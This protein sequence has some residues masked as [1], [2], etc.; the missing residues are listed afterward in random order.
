MLT[1]M[2]LARLSFSRMVRDD[3]VRLVSAFAPSGARILDF[4]GRDGDLAEGLL[5][6][7]FQVGI[8]EPTEGRRD[9]GVF[10]NLTA[11]TNWLGFF[12]PSSREQFDIVCVFG[13]LEHFLE[14]TFREDMALLATYCTPGGKIIGTVPL[15]EAL[16]QGYCLCPGCASLFHRWQHQR[17]F[18][19]ESLT[20][21]LRN[22]GLVHCHTFVIDFSIC[23]GFAAGFKDFPLPEAHVAAPQTLH[24][25]L[26][27]ARHNETRLRAEHASLQQRVEV[28]QGAREQLQH[29]RDTVG[30]HNLETFKHH[31]FAAKVL[32]YAL[33]RV[34]GI[35][36]RIPGFSRFRRACTKFLHMASNARYNRSLYFY[37][38]KVAQ[39]MTEDW[40]TAA[41]FFP[42]RPLSPQALTGKPSLLFFCGTLGA[43][44]A[45]R[46]LANL[47]IRMHFAGH[48]VKVRLL[49]LD[50]PEAHYAP[51][52]RK[53]GIDCRALSCE[54]IEKNASYLA[55]AGV[56][57]AL[58]SALPLEVRQNTAA[59]AAEVLRE[60]VDLIHTFLD[61]S[62]IIAAWAG[63]L[64][65]TPAMR[66]SCRNLNPSRFFYYQPWM[67]A[68]YRWLARQPRI[69]LEANSRAAAR[70]YE[71]WLDLPEDSINVSPNGIDSAQ[72]VTLSDTERKQLRAELGVPHGAPLVISVGRIGPEKRP[73]DLMHVF[74]RTIE[75]MPKAHCVHV[76]H[77]LLARDIAL[78]REKLPD[79]QK[80]NIHLLGLRQDIFR[81]LAASDVFVL[82]SEHESMP[83]AVME[84]MLSGL[85][86]VATNAGGT[87]ELV[88]EGQTGFLRD[89][90]DIAGL[91]EKTVFL[92]CNPTLRE[93]MG[94]AGKKRMEEFSFD[95]LMEREQ[96]AYQKQ[97]AGYSIQEKTGKKSVA[98]YSLPSMGHFLRIQSRMLFTRHVQPDA[99]TP[100][101]PGLSRH[102]ELSP[103]AHEGKP[104]VTFFLGTLGSGGAER[105]VCL[106]ARE[107]KRKGCLVRVVVMNSIGLNGHRL[108]WLREEGIPCFALHTHLPS[109][110]L[111]AT[112]L[113]YLNKVLAMLPRQDRADCMALCAYLAQDPPDVLHCF[114]DHSNIIGAYAGLLTGIPALR[115]SVCAMNP[116]NFAFYQEWW[117][118]SYQ[119]LLKYPQIRLE[120]NSHFVA[121]DYQ[122]W[123]NLPAASEFIPTAVDRTS[124]ENLPAD[125]REQT[126][127]NL[128]LDNN[129]PLVLGVLRLS[130]EKCPFDMLLAF[131]ELRKRQPAA[132]LIHAGI[133]PLQ[134]ETE[135]FARTLHLEDSVSFLGARHDVPALMLAADALLLTSRTE[136]FPNVLLEAM[137]SGRPFVAPRVGGIPE[138]AEDGEYGFLTEHGDV[139]AMADRLALLLEN[140]ELA[141]NMGTKG[142]PRL[143]AKHT[144]E[145]LAA[146][147]LAAYDRQFTALL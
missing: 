50:G 102:R 34:G 72:A 137:A 101:I 115:L 143:A 69:A 12:D 62:N 130:E 45:E 65:G 83:N 36:R 37:G 5:Q 49:S 77:G 6:A 57:L 108:P 96:A 99:S 4:G 128:G 94:R 9:R 122:T 117:R 13:V 124:F 129:T 29:L 19:K 127:Q 38:P 54:N 63:L 80:E 74:Q 17:S 141:R 110:L 1:E 97:L 142:K 104:K 147:A 3:L 95:A 58:L 138:L 67:E 71:L 28:L 55:T 51:L 82:C 15:E 125:A 66:L 88:L 139:V 31:V 81:L 109:F 7:G 116:S 32:G 8:H 11:H 111:P 87:M 18:D 61:L 136:G 24:E 59:L 43:G 76:G 86:V 70:E 78:W 42:P 39:E 113:P 79:V 90:G 73:F 26:A 123:L 107:L 145:L 46:Q 133:G 140:A 112:N 118:P 105:Q 20:A 134:E 100:I 92:L 16:E 30:E 131:A 75:L 120:S 22:A 121:Q 135:Q 106:L 103:T 132:R 33:R 114:L 64:T 47:A 85:P 41:H 93:E 68:H 144:A 119:Y 44:G 25:A 2:P 91:T 48:K 53:A 98:P 14:G 40:P 146:T 27:A 52:L 10:K 60:P 126:R 56:D 35:A 21:A 23:L 89:V 84:A